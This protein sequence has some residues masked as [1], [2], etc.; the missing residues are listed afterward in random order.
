MNDADSICVEVHRDETDHFSAAWLNFWHMGGWFWAVGGAIGSASCAFAL[1]L[2]S[3]ASIGPALGGG[4]VWASI[5]TFF[6]ATMILGDFWDKSRIFAR[7][8]FDPVT[9]VF[10]P[11]TLEIRH[12]AGERSMRWRELRRAFDNKRVMVVR[13]G[14]PVML[15]VPKRQLAAGA[16][17]A[18]KDLLRNAMSGRTAF[19]D[20]RL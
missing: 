10:S 19:E 11:D 3:G 12:K 20:D 18:L 1:G 9:Y 13:G 5:F 6:A 8:P 14:G 15:V 2:A 17:A 7:T 4:L 16:E